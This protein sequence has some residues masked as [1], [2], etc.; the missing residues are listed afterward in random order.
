[1]DCGEMYA[2]TPKQVVGVGHSLLH[3]FAR[4]CVV[5][6]TTYISSWHHYSDIYLSD[7]QK[8]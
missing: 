7:T 4:I 6:F 5:P 8:V 2:L 1:M 3:I